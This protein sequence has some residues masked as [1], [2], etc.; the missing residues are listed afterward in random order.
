MIL[1]DGILVGAACAL[2]FGGSLRDIARVGLRAE[3]LLP[4]GLAIQLVGPRI[5]VGLNRIALLVLLWLMPAGAMMLAAFLNRRRPG[6]A[7]M[8]LGVLLNFIVVSANLGMPVLLQNAIVAGA[9]GT[10]QEALS[11]SW[12]HHASSPAD[13]FLVLADVIPVPGPSWHRGM[14]SIGDILLSVGA[15]VFVFVSSNPGRRTG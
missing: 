11:E 12:L 10:A 4:V 7:L 3:Y 14:I 1:L 2:I 9:P 8:G 5:D 6:M 15:A 13:R